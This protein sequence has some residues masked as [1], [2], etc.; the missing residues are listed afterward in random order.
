MT[1][2]SAK[3]PLPVTLITSSEDHSFFFN[4]RDADVKN[5]ALL[6]SEH[7]IRISELLFNIYC[8]LPILQASNK[9]IDRQGCGT[10]AGFESAVSFY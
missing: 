2:A 9:A 7:I 8:S 6:P 10:I 1:I 5:A 3:G 4:Q